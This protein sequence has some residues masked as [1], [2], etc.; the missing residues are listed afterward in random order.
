M[1]TLLCCII[2]PL[3]VC[4]LPGRAAAWLPIWLRLRLYN[5]PRSSCH[6]ANFDALPNLHVHLV[7]PMHTG[8]CMPT[9]STHSCWPGV[10]R[11]TAAAAAAQEVDCVPGAAVA[12]PCAI[13]RPCGCANPAAGSCRAAK[14]C[15]QMLRVWGRRAAPPRQN[16]CCLCLAQ[17]LFSYASRCAFQCDLCSQGAEAQQ[18][19]RRSERDGTWVSPRAWRSAKKLCCQGAVARS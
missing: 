19:C 12:L 8:F 15:C 1:C 17:H 2:T 10:V 9:S 4:P 11:R 5:P 3:Y 14:G 6:F 13:N 7:S 16:C 18:E